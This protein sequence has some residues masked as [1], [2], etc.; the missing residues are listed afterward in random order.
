[1]NPIQMVD[2]TGQYTRLQAEMDEAIL[3]T[4]R[5]GQYI[6]G[7]PVQRFSEELACFTGSGYVIPCGNGT[8]ALQIALM[9]LDLNPG[10]EVIVPAF[11]YAAAAEAVALLR[12]IPVAVDVD[13]HSFNIDVEKIRA[14][15]SSKTRAIIPVHLFGQT[16]DMEPIMQIAFE[17]GLYVLED[18]AQNIGSIYNFN[19]NID[20][21]NNSI[22]EKQAG[23][24][25][26]IGTLSFFPT[27]NLGCYGDGGAILTGDEALA[28]K[29]KMIAIHGQSGK[30]VHEVIGCNSRLDNLQ[31]AIL[32]VKL[33]H[34]NDFTRRRQEAA[35]F[36]REGL[37]PLAEFIELPQE[38]SYSTHVY[39]Q[40]TIQVKDSRRDELQA[41][42]KK[43]G[44]PTIVYYPYSLHQQP[45]FR[46]IT[47]IG[48]DLSVS[49]RLC[50]TVLSLPMHTE[51]E[52]E[53]QE[54]I[55]RQ[56]K[57]FYE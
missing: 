8:D 5:S 45:A 20:L 15:I 23:T 22:P 21:I 42:L 56:L 25:G 47:R 51:L 2:L 53:Q 31:A 49:E 12:L 46:E 27:K 11:T 4:A 38:M 54:Y 16:A 7:E 43:Q 33:R 32:R 28:K 14:A 34:L 13:P 37:S 24:I 18:N 1:M 3:S 40:F 17:Y 6:N 36:Y 10:D 29:L 52:R 50:R 41:Y 48:G 39:N 44:I 35:S 55:I 19:K 30:Y 26:H 9:A 57:H